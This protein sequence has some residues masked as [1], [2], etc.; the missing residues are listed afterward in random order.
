MSKRI[1]H[2]W[3][4][5]LILGWIWDFLFWDKTPGISFAIFVGLCV[6]SGLFLFFIEKQKPSAKS[7]ILLIPITVFSILSFIRQEPLSLLLSI[8]C[9]LLVLQILAMSILG[10]SW[11][12]YGF[13]DYLSGFLN[14]C[15][16]VLIHPVLATSRTKE[17]QNETAK[18]IPSRKIWHVMRGILIAL[19]IMIIYTTLLSAA[20]A[21]FA[22]KIG[23]FIDIFSIERLPEYILRFMVILFIAYALVGVYYHSLEKSILKVVQTNNGSGIIP[24]LGFTEAV[25]V[26]G[27]ISILFTSFVI[28]QFQY[29][30]GGQTNI[31]ID[32]YTYS[33]YARRGFG[34]LISVAIF[35]LALIYSLSHITRRETILHRRVFSVLN[36][37]LVSLLSIILVSAFQRLLLYESFYGFT[38]LRTYSHV[39]II[40]LGVLL[41]ITVILEILQRLRLFTNS[42]LLVALGFA[43]SINFL[44]VD[45]FIVQRNAQRAIQGDE[46]DTAYLASLSTDAVPTLVS[47]YQSPSLPAQTRDALGASLACMQ[48]IKPSVVLP[49][50]N[51]QSFQLSHWRARNALLSIDDRLREYHTFNNDSF[52]KVTSPAQ[53]VYWCESNWRFD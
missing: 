44:N 48:K 40:W 8:S 22:Q 43:L 6:L 34:E 29:F 26:L 24:F 52:W 4:T 17:P 7:L 45:G 39:F 21:I 19:P 47:L 5:A 1:N 10:D 3:L 11:L 25:I 49:Q 51:W 20:D 23:A 13:I 28:I 27:G 41:V 14:L 50:K 35:T 33:E 18:K 46:V 42:V 9:T 38:R 12:K 31:H 30:F 15:Q 16:S 32:G 36:F 53:E 37:F 2:Y